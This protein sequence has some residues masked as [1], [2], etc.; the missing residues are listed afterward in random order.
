MRNRFGS[1]EYGVGLPQ[2]GPNPQNSR[3]RLARKAG[4]KKSGL[5]IRACHARHARRALERLAAFFNNQ[6][7]SLL[8]NVIDKLTPNGKVEAGGIDQLLK[9]FQGKMG[10]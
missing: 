7:S 8:P 6:L 1:L 10:A 3:A 2:N 9:M 4:H 5:A